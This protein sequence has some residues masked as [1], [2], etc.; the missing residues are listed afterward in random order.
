[1]PY[2]GFGWNYEIFFF[3]KDHYQSD[4]CKL[5]SGLYT[6]LSVLSEEKANINKFFTYFREWLLC[7]THTSKGYKSIRVRKT[8]E[9]KLCHFWEK[10]MK[11]KQSS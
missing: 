7:V 4:S 3:L 9:K 11:H 1:M 8:E 10:E 5:V 6:F 2:K